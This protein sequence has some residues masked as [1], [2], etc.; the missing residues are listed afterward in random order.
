MGISGCRLILLT[1][2]ACKILN[3][4]SINNLPVS[5]PNF[6][7]FSYSHQIYSKVSPA[8]DLPRVHPQCEFTGKSQVTVL[9]PALPAGPKEV[10]ILPVEPVHS[11]A[12]AAH[13]KAISVSTLSVHIKVELDI[14]VM[15]GVQFHFRPYNGS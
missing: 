15:E 8:T 1:H 9:N 3:H 5:F 14:N 13:T 6:V 4:Y 12:P 2:V 7:Y 11:D 10:W